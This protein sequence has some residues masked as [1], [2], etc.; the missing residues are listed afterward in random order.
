[1]PDSHLSGNTVSLLIAGS[2][3]HVAGESTSGSTTSTTS[4]S[5]TTTTY[6]GETTTT[7]TVPS[8][9]YT[10]TQLEPWNPYPCT[11]GAPTTTT[12]PVKKTLKK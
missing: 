4:I 7:T 10:N 11:L 5:T 12:V 3:L 6:P 2:S 9:V 8:D 1:M